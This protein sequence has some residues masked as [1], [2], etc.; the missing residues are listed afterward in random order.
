M[1]EA[2]ATGCPVVTTD[3]G[4]VGEAI[5]DNIHGFVCPPDSEKFADKI[6][7]LAQSSELQKTFSENG[8]RDCKNW[9]LEH[10][11]KIFINLLQQA[12]KK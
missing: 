10:Q 3:S 1:V 6:L 12:A 11:T 5:L 9:E 4:C 8:I 2:A 7:E